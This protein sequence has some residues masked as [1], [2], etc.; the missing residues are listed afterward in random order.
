M[1]HS[2]RYDVVEFLNQSHL[3]KPYRIVEHYP[4]CDGVRSRL[5]EK[6]FKSFFEAR[7][8]KERLEAQE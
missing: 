5:T 2:Y 6:C 4:T 8:E 1:A 7:L 3:Q